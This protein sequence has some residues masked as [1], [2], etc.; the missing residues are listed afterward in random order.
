M[1]YLYYILFFAVLNIQAQDYK[2]YFDPACKW[3]VELEKNN[4]E[5]NDDWVL[6]VYFPHFG[7]QPFKPLEDFTYYSKKEI[8][9]QVEKYGLVSM[10][11][12]LLYSKKLTD[13]EEHLLRDKLDAMDSDYPQALIKVKYDYFQFSRNPAEFHHEMEEIFITDLE[14]LT[15]IPE[16]DS[17]IFWEQV[18]DSTPQELKDSDSYINSNVDW[19]YDRYSSLHNELFQMNEPFKDYIFMHTYTQY[20]F[21]KT[22]SFV[23]PNGISYFILFHDNKYTSLSGEIKYTKKSIKKQLK[24]L[25]ISSPHS[26][27]KKLSTQIELFSFKF[28]E[29][30]HP[31]IKK[32]Y[33]EFEQMK[34][35][36][37][38][39]YKDYID[40]T[41]YSMKVWSSNDSMS[42]IQSEGISYTNPDPLQLKIEELFQILTSGKNDK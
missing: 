26:S 9:E 6:G 19:I 2:K 35:N 17:V 36:V 21:R 23:L 1:K 25:Y 24:K 42:G 15:N 39:S 11:Y 7:G 30:S 4:K 16:K 34:R 8:A 32:W 14:F 40:N 31:K 27:Q 38:I 13:S 29:D 37:N 22:P 18:L 3:N 33:S 28:D 41:K 5:N 20:Q 12:D 10:G